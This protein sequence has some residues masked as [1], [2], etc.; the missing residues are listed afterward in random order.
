MHPSAGCVS[1]RSGC[2]AVRILGLAA[3]NPL[4]GSCVSKCSRCGAVRILGFAGSTFAG[5][6]RVETLSLWRCTIFPPCRLAVAP[7]KFAT[8]RLEHPETSLESKIFLLF[9]SRG[10]A[11]AWIVLRT[12]C[13]KRRA[14]RCFGRVSS[15]ACGSSSDFGCVAVLARGASS[16]CCLES[17]T[18]SLFRVHG[19]AAA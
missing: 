10:S 3:A 16:E 12:A 19:R 18:F 2:G 11:G 13:W 14:S 5:T 9:W 1:K 7:C 6:V 8:S 15:L 4:Q 17:T